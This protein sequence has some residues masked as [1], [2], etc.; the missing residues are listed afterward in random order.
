M[1]T[2]WKNAHPF[3]DLPLELIGLSSEVADAKENWIRTKTRLGYAHRDLQDASHQIAA[4]RPPSEEEI[5]S[6]HGAFE[7]ELEGMAST[8]LHSESAEAIVSPDYERRAISF[9][10]KYDLGAFADIVGFDSEAAWKL[11]RG[12]KLFYVLQSLAGVNGEEAWEIRRQALS[13]GESRPDAPGVLTSLVGLESEEAWNIRERCVNTDPSNVL[14]SMAGLDSERAWDMRKRFVGDFDRTMH[15]DVVI[16]LLKSIIGLDSEAAWLIRKRA[17]ESEK[18]PWII[19]DAL[20]DSLMGLDNEAAWAFRKNL[21]ANR[22]LA[23]LALVDSQ[24]AWEIR[25]KGFKKFLQNEHPD[26]YRESM[27]LLGVDSDRAWEMREKIAKT[28]KKTMYRNAGLSI[29]SVEMIGARKAML[30][31]E[32]ALVTA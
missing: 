29:G 6:R 12:R 23:S 18:D 25:E 17:F 1:I 13:T 11:R 32:Q 3:E 21:S 31:R 2:E 16:P 15:P 19:E 4:A 7:K 20:A 22:L 8:I 9:L 24:E 30:D 14:V 5:R 28:L 26:G 10:K 27:M